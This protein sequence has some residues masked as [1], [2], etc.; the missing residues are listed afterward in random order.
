MREELSRMP[1]PSLDVFHEPLYQPR[2]VARFMQLNPPRVRRW[3]F[4]RKADVKAQPVIA[5]EDGEELC[6][7]L[8]LV[9]VRFVSELLKSGF[10][11]QAIRRIKDEAAALVGQ[12]DHPLSR[13]KFYEI[14]PKKLFM[15]KGTGEM[16][17]ARTGGQLALAPVIH[18]VG[19][20]IDFH[21]GLASRWWP[22]Q[23]NHHVVLDPRHSF[24]A[25]TVAGH[26]IKTWNV[27]D[28][29]L[30]EGRDLVR[31]CRWFNI[32]EDE[33][34]DA[35]AFEERLAGAAPAA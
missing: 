25:P 14:G 1:L 15:Q 23:K 28:L 17:E 4:G 18:L 5:R 6:S 12:A 7:F 26:G 9:E 8:D 19:E 31:V 32:S 24:G 35:I 33:A 30:G 20:E 2:D 3:V 29:Y 10:S 16:V 21:A 27:F 13:L 22:L 11:L 34:R